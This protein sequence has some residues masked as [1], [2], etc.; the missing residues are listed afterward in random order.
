MKL[1]NETS[2]K[3]LHQH[4]GGNNRSDIVVLGSVWSDRRKVGQSDLL[5]ASKVRFCLC[6]SVCKL[7]NN[8]MTLSLHISEN[9]SLK[10]TTFGLTIWKQINVIRLLYGH[11]DVCDFR[12]V[13]VGIYMSFFAAADRV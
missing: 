9:N 3:F 5:C 1:T 8:H 13:T 11:I 4:I 7:Y 6:L 10:I 2:E 12:F